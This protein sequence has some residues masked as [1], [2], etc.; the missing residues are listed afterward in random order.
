[1][2]SA[3]MIKPLTPDQLPT[4]KR[5]MPV[6]RKARTGIVVGNQ[7]PVLVYAGMGIWHLW[8]TYNDTFTGG[9]YL[10]LMP[11]G[12]IFSDTV[13]GH[14]GINRDTIKHTVEDPEI[15]KW[16][17]SAKLPPSNPKKRM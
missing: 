8:L 9:S 15:F 7:T 11:D 3:P 5:R 16:I 4:D 14:R 13:D 1:M 10:V 2:G 12:R 17:N 6:P